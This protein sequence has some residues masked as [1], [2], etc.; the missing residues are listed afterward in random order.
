MFRTPFTATGYCLLQRTALGTF[1]D[2]LATDNGLLPRTTLETFIDLFAEI[3]E[4]S[5]PRSL[6]AGIMVT[7]NAITTP[8][9]AGQPGNRQATCRQQVGSKCG[10]EGRKETQRNNGSTSVW[11]TW[12]S[13][14]LSPLFYLLSLLS[15]LLE[16]VVV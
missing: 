12:F 11:L 16:R 7:C 2:L 1:I 13:S 10:V 6:Q 5:E 9:S 8:N 14:F 15:C 3:D 4:C